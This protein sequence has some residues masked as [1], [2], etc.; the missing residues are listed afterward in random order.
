MSP[1]TTTGVAGNYNKYDYYD[2]KSEALHRWALQL[3]GIVG[4][5]AANVVPLTRSD[6][7]QTTK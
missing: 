7:E 2:E 3:R 6:D 1:V 4:G 5:G